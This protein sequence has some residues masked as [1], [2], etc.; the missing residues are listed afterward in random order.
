MLT[1][2][3]ATQLKSDISALIDGVTEV[4]V[5]PPQPTAS[6]NVS[7]NAIWKKDGKAMKGNK[8]KVRCTLLLFFVATVVNGQQLIIDHQSWWRDHIDI[9]ETTSQPWYTGTNSPSHV[10][11]RVTATNGTSGFPY[12]GT[13]SGTL[14]LKIHIEAFRQPAGTKL[15]NLSCIRP[16]GCPFAVTQSLPVDVSSPTALYEG[17]FDVTWDTVSSNQNQNVDGWK[18]VVFSATLERPDGK[19]IV[20]RTRC[21][22]NFQNGFAEE[23]YSEAGTTGTGGW[24]RDGELTTQYNNMRV[25]QDVLEDAIAGVPDTWQF[26]VYPAFNKNSVQRNLSVFVDPH[27]HDVS[28][29]PNGNP[30]IVIVDQAVPRSGRFQVTIDTSG[31]APGMHKLFLRATENGISPDGESAGVVVIPFLVE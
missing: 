8:M 29:F 23:G 18:E 9:A 22:L 10:H 16:F 20:V 15:V 31:L 2:S 19:L 4:P 1:Q 11:L 27:G 5:P 25:G 6:I 21:F 12:N 13:V 24:M 26:Y 14:S 17:D 3:Q 30:G 7:P 28:V